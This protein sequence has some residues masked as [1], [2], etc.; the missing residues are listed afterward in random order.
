MRTFPEAY[1]PGAATVLMPN[2]IRE[3]KSDWLSLYIKTSLWKI[4]DGQRKDADILPRT[5][6]HFL[7]SRFKIRLQEVFKKTYKAHRKMP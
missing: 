2:Q 1:L 7:T 3:R 6:F 5:G 4:P